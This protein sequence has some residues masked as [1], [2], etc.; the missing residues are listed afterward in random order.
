MRIESKTLAQIAKYGAVGVLNTFLTLFVIFLCKSVMGVNEY[1]SNA[2]GYTVGFVNSFFFNK[3][4][5]FRSKGGYA[6]EGVKFCIGFMVCYCAQLTVVWAINQSWF[7]DTEYD[8]MGVFTISGYGVATLLGNV[9]YTACNFA[10][11]KFVAFT[12]QTTNN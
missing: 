10:Y 6:S 1:A 4:W 11:N 9:V 5:V 12:K 2:L 3:K 7:G 8:I